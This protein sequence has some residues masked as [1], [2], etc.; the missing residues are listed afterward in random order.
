MPYK[1][2]YRAHLSPTSS[3][4]PIPTLHVPYP[5]LAI[6]QQ[7][8]HTPTLGFHAYC[9]FCVECSSLNNFFSYIF[10]SLHKCH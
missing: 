9:S 7:T 5:L 2:L 6:P 10:L 8:K 3:P 1:A 4:F